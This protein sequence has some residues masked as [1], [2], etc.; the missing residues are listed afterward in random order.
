MV[1][2][3][4]GNL[5]LSGDGLQIALLLVVSAVKFHSLSFFE[6]QWGVYVETDSSV[7]RSGPLSCSFRA[8]WFCSNEEEGSYRRNQSGGEVVSLCC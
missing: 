5:A 2:F 8:K 7:V 6:F 1:G 3:D 4:L